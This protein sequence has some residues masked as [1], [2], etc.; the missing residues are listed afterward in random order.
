MTLHDQLVLN[1][2]PRGFTTTSCDVESCRNTAGAGR[3]PRRRSPEDITGGR[4]CCARWGGAGALRG[5]APVPPG[6]SRAD[7]AVERDLRARLLWR[8]ADDS[9]CDPH[10]HRDLQAGAGAG[11]RRCSPAQPAA[12]APAPEPMSQGFFGTFWRAHLEEFRHAPSDEPSLRNVPLPGPSGTHGLPARSG[13]AAPLIARSLGLGG[14]LA[15]GSVHGADGVP[16]ARPRLVHR[17]SSSATTMRPTAIAA[18]GKPQ[19]SRLN[20][21]RRGESR[22]HSP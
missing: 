1:L 22:I 13:A 5:P 8:N 20:P 21:E 9:T 2:H 19:T 11:E 12:V 6:R 3:H 17:R 14:S 4:G 18:I 7:R 16:A 15:H 10:F